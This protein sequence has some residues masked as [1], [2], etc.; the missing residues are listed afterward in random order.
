MQL[1]VGTESGSATGG[2]GR[3]LGAGG[4][5]RPLAAPRPRQVVLC[6]GCHPTA[7]QCP[8]RGRAVPE[9]L[10]E[11]T[12][13]SPQPAPPPPPRLHPP[14]PST[15]HRARLHQPLS[16]CKPSIPVLAGE[17]KQFN[18]VAAARQHPA[19]GAHGTWECILSQY[20]ER[21][22]LPS[23]TRRLLFLQ[24]PRWLP[25]ALGVPPWDRLSSVFASLG[26]RFSCL[27]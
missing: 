10:Q 11:R 5:L 8:R 6:G 21:S 25:P 2:A 17:G 13:L 1:K 24:C 4:Q 7:P 19:A 12:A 9:R 20:T 15:K 22:F 27:W 26:C 14:P 16:L 23:S 3:L 18:K